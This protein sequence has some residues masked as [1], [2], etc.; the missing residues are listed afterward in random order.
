MYNQNMQTI[1][2]YDNDEAY[3]QT[4]ADTIQ[5]AIAD[6]YDFV[7]GDIAR[8]LFRTI[9]I[10][11]YPSEAIALFNAVGFNAPINKIFTG[12]IEEVDIY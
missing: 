7:G 8:E 6:L 2:I 9:V 5:G 4:K 1:I 11:L 12:C 3:F 10:K